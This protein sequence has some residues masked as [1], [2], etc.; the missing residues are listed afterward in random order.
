MLLELL[1]E[2]GD[3]GVQRTPQD[4][5]PGTKVCSEMASDGGALEVALGFV[6]SYSGN[7]GYS[8]EDSL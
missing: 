4:D 1:G 5:A 2:V 6:W 8:Q 7:R 3:V